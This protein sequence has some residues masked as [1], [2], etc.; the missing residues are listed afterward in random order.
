MIVLNKH[1]AKLKNWSTKIPNAPYL[2]R[3]KQ[4][5]KTAETIPLKKKIKVSLQIIKKIQNDRKNKA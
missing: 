4:A 3:Y 2:N 1:S 5:K